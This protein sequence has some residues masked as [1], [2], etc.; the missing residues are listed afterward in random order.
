MQ[1][2]EKVEKEKYAPEAAS[3]KASLPRRFGENLTRYRKAAGMTQAQL[4]ALLNYSDKIVSKW[5][6]GDGLPDLPTTIALSEILGVS[7]D[8]LLQAPGEIT[9]DEKATDDLP[10]VPPQAAEEEKNGESTPGRRI[11]IHL[12]SSLLPFLVAAAAYATLQ[13]VGATFGGELLFLYA[14]AA[15]GIVSTVFSCLWW[16]ALPKII[17]VSLICWGVAFSFWLSLRNLGG[18]AAIFAAAAVMQVLTVLWF[19][20]PKRKKADPRSSPDKTD[21]SNG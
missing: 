16:G 1:S 9:A 13:M 8:T 6:R 11:F 20:M 12:L 5:E 21:I 14:V 3:E 2:A 17:S 7:V 19:L 10:S 15:S 4:A 18:A